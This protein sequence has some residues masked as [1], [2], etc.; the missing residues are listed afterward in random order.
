MIRPA[1]KL[2]LSL[3]DA[4]NERTP[5]DRLSLF[6][7]SCVVMIGCTSPP[8][9]AA[10][11]LSDAAGADMLRSTLPS[12]SDVRVIDLV[13][14]V[15]RVE[16]PLDGVRQTRKIW[17]HVDELRLD[18]ALPAKLARNG[19]R[20]GVGSPSA[21]PAIRAILDAA[22]ADVRRDHLVAQG[23]LPLVIQLAPVSAPETIFSYTS[24][25]RLVGK[26]VAGGD[27]LLSI[28]YAFHPQLTGAVDLE[29]G[30]EVR[31]DLGV[32]TWERRD[33][34]IRQVPDYQR[35]VFDGLGFRV[36]LATD[37][38][39]VIGVHEEADNEYLVGHRFLIRE[40][41]GRRFESLFFVTPKP[42]QVRA[43]RRRS[44]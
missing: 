34:A 26:T 11:W 2:I 7:A 25:G 17:N 16:L 9:K 12:H 41:A 44:P 20:V 3:V 33:G 42:Y 15:A 43:P 5:H 1:D 8:P 31:R 4:M 29:L 37:E 40:R 6:L 24:A 28:D 32:M 39:L 18:S 27:K 23:G 13:F 19:L 10:D 22:D 21:W 35:H 30:F 36:T 14:D 38:F